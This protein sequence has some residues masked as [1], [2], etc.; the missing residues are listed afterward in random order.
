MNSTLDVQS[1]EIVEDELWDH[2]SGL[3]NPM[4]Y[5]SEVETKDNSG[6]LYPDCICQGNEITDCK[7]KNNHE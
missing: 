5:Q 2:Y 1:T 6:C 4:S 7:N 3:P